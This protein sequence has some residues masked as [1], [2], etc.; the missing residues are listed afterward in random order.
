MHLKIENFSCIKEAHIDI[1]RIN[2]LI[3]PQASGKSVISKL[4]YYFYDIFDKQLS[5][6]EDDSEYIEF[7]ESLKI[8][9]IKTFP[10]A[11]WGPNPFDIEYQ[12]GEYQ[13]SISRAKPRKNSKQTIS[14]VLSGNFVEKYNRSLNK[15]RKIRQDINISTNSNSNY[16]DWESLW[17]VRRDINAELKSELGPSYSYSQLFIPAGRSFFTSMGKAIMAFEQG[18][19]L[20]PLTIE[21]GRYFVSM[22]DVLVGRHIIYRPKPPSK[23]LTALRSSLAK[24]FF[25]G[26]IR[27]DRNEEYIETPDRRKIPFAVMSSGQQELLPLWLAV[28]EFLYEDT[29]GASVFIEEPEAHLFPSTQSKLTQYLANLVNRVNGRMFLTTHSPYLLSTV[30][31]LLKAGTLSRTKSKSNRQWQGIIDEIVPKSAWLFP[32]ST[33]AYAI[34]NGKVKQIIDEDGLI[35]GEYLDSV[36]S[37]LAYEFTN[38]LEIESTL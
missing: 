25:G 20:D 17:K 23:E 35:D 19:Y 8:S 34:I 32:E 21:F 1:K 3:G 12:V 16:R 29:D 38:L 28:N 2:I 15:F 36:S 10:I 6:I 9:F 30:N 22:K 18:G 13:F 5:A 11:A 24:E 7:I 27:A 26:E 31:N 4:A 37:E 14:I 33:S